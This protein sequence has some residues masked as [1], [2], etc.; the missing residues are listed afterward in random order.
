MIRT[1]QTTPA[2]LVVVADGAGTKVGFGV[3]RNDLSRDGI[4]LA[5]DIAKQSAMADP[6]FASLPR[7]LHGGSPDPML[8]DPGVV[9]LPDDAVAA[10]A[11]EMLDGA[12]S[13][14]SEAGVEDSIQLKGEV[15][16]RA[17]MLVVGNSHGLLAE[18]TWTSLQATLHGHIGRQ[19]G[20]GLGSHSGTHLRNFSPRDAGVE[21]ATE[22]RRGRPAS[23]RSYSARGPSPI[24]GRTSCCPPSAS[25]PWQMAAVR[26][27]TAST[28]R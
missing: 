21:A 28:S 3:D 23:T 26:L 6:G 7:P 8:H 1:G 18:D 19:Q 20:Y 17:E 5:L 12:L 25:T 13:T 22:A 16:S 2:V 24:C 9:G 10:L 14:F 27:R 11:S 4:I 15:R